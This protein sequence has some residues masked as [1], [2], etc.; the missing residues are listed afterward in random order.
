MPPVTLY[1][2]PLSED[3]PNRSPQKISIIANKKAIQESA[4]ASA[5]QNNQL[6]H[7][8]NNHVNANVDYYANNEN[9]RHDTDDHFYNMDEQMDLFSD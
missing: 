8:N 6:R 9:R 2:A 4:S 7:N 3:E 5:L 1:E